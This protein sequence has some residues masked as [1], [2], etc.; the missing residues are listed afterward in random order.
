MN[1]NNTLFD[2]SQFSQSGRV[3]K[4]CRF[5]DD[6][7][8]RFVL[9][10]E[11]LVYSYKLTDRASE[12]VVWVM[13]YENHMATYQQI[14]TAINKGKRTVQGW[15]AC[16]RDN[17]LNGLS[18]APKCGAPVK[19]TLAMRKS[20]IRL[21]GEKFTY[22]EIARACSISVS[23]V[24]KVLCEYTKTV[25][26]RQEEI[27][28]NTNEPEEVAR[29]DA[30]LNETQVVS[31][32]SKQA[33]VVKNAKQTSSIISDQRPTSYSDKAED[34]LSKDR[35]LDRILAAKGLMQDAPPLFSDCE[36]AE[37]AGGFMAL[38][39]L[40][41]DAVLTTAMRVY[42][43]L[44][45]S[46]YGLRTMIVT[47]V[48]MALLRIKS[49]EGIRKKDVRSLG[50]LLGLDRAPE[51]KTLR[52]KLHG[53]VKMQKAFQWMKELA[54]A[55]VAECKGPVT[56]IQ[57]D[58]HIIA[59]SGKQKVGTVYSSRTKQ[60]TKG[61]TENWVNL[62]NGGGLFMITSPFNEGLSRML[63]P[64]VK[65]AVKI[66][67]QSSLNLVFDRGGYNAEV[68]ERLINSGHHIVTYR[69]GGYE[70]I[71]LENFQ[72]K[73]ITIGRRTY[74]YAPY[75][76]KVSINVYTETKNKK[77]ISVRK[78]TKRTL[79][80]REIRIVR[81]DKR[82]TAILTSI[83]KKEMKAEKV[84]ATLFN[85][86][87]SQENYFK[88]MRQE[89]KLD[90]T[91][92]YDTDVI[93]DIDLTHP[94][95]VYV[96]LEKKKARIKEKRR[97]KLEKYAAE[98]IDCS[99]EEAAEILKKDGKTKEAETIRQL[100]K[101]IDQLQENIKNT[102]PRENVSEAQ[103]KRLNEECRIFQNC[104]RTSAFKIESK[105][106]D[107]LNNIYEKPNKEVH[108]LIA[109]ALKTSGSI[110]LDNNRVVIRLLP[111]S[112]RTRTRAI[113]KLLLQLNHMQARIPGSNR[114]IYFEQTPEPIP[115]LHNI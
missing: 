2:N 14:A 12:R 81:D 97:I 28:L 112:S 98:L 54:E 30:T 82:Q 4:R 69:K 57:I 20:I 86:T 29:K 44:G 19:I 76:K 13:I 113:N 107:M 45:S 31:E 21:R 55:R 48:L 27:S 92:M 53:F 39:M 103:Y 83:P 25:E 49:N 106:V 10:D 17:G 102:L 110:R 94:N 15:V 109:A 68:F 89:F 5:V 96:K 37:W 75:E 33:D 6:G 40:S 74:E 87:G 88:Y 70:D 114:I 78:K 35:S 72:K 95:P 36:H 11:I 52:R 34:A 93:D 3:S 51:V 104:I 101:K 105:L 43:T 22:Y 63:E 16:Y 32:I 79:E 91:G 90:A 8:M 24:R 99:P 66:C 85:R 61:Q 46:F 50:R 41:Q 9:Q 60:V 84:A 67:G 58:G 108:S 115:V 1:T 62:P 64:V 42:K 111:Q 77:G 23:S 100:N 18:D 47:W 26:G 73:E 80:L 7:D 59:Y 65:E 38:A 56:T 71:P